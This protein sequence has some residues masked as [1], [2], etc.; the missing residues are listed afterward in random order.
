MIPRTLPVDSSGFRIDARLP[1][2]R[3]DIFVIGASLGGFEAAKTLVSELPSNL[4]ACLFVVLHIG[5]HGLGVLPEILEKAGPLPASNAKDGEAIKEGHMYVAPPDYHLILE[6]PGLVRISRGPRENGVRPAIDPLFRSAA[7]A[8]G[9][10]VVGVI[11]TGSLDDGTAGLWA[12]KMRGGTAIVQE[13]KE[14]LAPSMPLSALKHVKVDFCL[15]LKE[16]APLLVKLSHSSVPEKAPLPMPKGIETEVKIAKETNA[17]EAG[18][19]EWG[20][21][22]IYSC[23]ECHGVLL[24]K[25]E[26]SN[27]RFRCH[28]GHAY[29][30]ESLLAGLVDRTEENLWSAIRSFDETVLLMR[31]M[32]AYFSENDQN[33][34]AEALLKR[35]DETERR[36]HALV[37]KMKT[38]VHESISG[39]SEDRKNP[40]FTNN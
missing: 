36:R 17:M 16:M 1:T 29:S 5:A 13:P 25:K 39:G 34:E 35:A 38:E 21:P 7:Y 12:I 8:F 23:P 30:L 6:R 37:Q 4:K 32:A 28:T 3:K 9:P 19:M 22:S 18:I 15:P 40:Q 31:R 26:G 33:A 2:A 20:K 11:L 24:E 10:R 27:L 14:A